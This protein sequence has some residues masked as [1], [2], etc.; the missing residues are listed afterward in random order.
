MPNNNLTERYVAAMNRIAKW[1]QPFC[2]W[3]LGSRL[4]GDPECDAVRDHREATIL[5]RVELTAVTKLL[6]DKGVFTMEE[7]QKGMIDECALLEQDYQ[8]KFPGMQATDIGIQYDQRA[9]E[10]MKNWKP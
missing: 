1:R 7:F 10:T 6:I 9:A 5:Q 8:K 4:K 3:Q 2:S